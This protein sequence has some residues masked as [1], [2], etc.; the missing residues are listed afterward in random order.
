MHI[1]LSY[2]KR[3]TNALTKTWDEKL[4]YNY[5]EKMVSD[6]VNRTCNDDPVKGVWNVYGN[7]ASSL[8][9]IVIVKA[10]GNTVE[11]TCWLRKDDT[12]HINMS[13]LILK[14]KNY[15]KQKQ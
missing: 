13:E 15:L 5:V 14:L 2:V 12:A 7:E 3:T 8:A 6:M 4:K 10:N 11:D 1:A 9:L